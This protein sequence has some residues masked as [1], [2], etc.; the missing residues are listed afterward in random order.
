V[1]KTKRWLERTAKWGDRADKSNPR[2]YADVLA[3]KKGDKLSPFEPVRDLFKKALPSS[4]GGSVSW[5][6]RQLGPSGI[7]FFALLCGA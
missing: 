7:V 5:G 4:V 2:Y 1:R 6:L 3:V